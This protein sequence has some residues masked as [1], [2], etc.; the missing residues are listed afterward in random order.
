MLPKVP[1]LGL[2]EIITVLGNEVLAKGC[3]PCLKSGC[4]DSGQ[5]YVVVPVGKVVIKG[6][7]YIGVV[8]YDSRA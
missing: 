7:A 8:F 5:P 3:D 6:P 2:T 4:F 1:F